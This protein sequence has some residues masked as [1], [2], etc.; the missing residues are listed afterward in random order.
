MLPRLLAG[1]PAIPAGRVS[2]REQHVV[3][4]RAAAALVAG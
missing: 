3:A 2:A 1:D 4:D